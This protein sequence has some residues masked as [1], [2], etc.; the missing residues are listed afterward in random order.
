M[1]NKIK[2]SIPDSWDEVTIEQFQEINSLS[3]D[4]EERN[5]EIISILINEDP[6]VVRKFSN[7]TYNKILSLLQWSNANPN[8][9]V[10]KT[11]LSVQGVEYGC[12]SRFNELS[13]G[14]MWDLDEYI[15]DGAI[16]NLHLI[17]SILYRP[18]VVA[19]NDRDR[20]IDEYDSSKL[21]IQAEIFRSN[22]MISDVYG[23]L[24]FFSLIKNQYFKV[25]RESQEQEMRVIAKNL[26]MM[27]NQKKKELKD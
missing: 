10:Y 17:M 20:L 13:I 18:L 7:I 9:A 14:E 2:L 11:I 8:D 12:L 27:K 1:T 3:S 26:E 22:V 21:P 5:L 4:N 15:N 23:V 16:K 24:F 25:M 19:F 6:E